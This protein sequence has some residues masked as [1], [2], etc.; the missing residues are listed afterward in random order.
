MSDLADF[1][2]DFCRAFGG[3]VE[4][5]A[6]G[7]HDVLLPESVAAQLSVEPLQR[8]AFDET[9]TGEPFTLL[10]YGHPLVERMVELAAASPACARLFI[11]DVRLHKT[12]LPALARAALSLSNASLAE[13]SGAIASR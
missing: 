3:I 7:V 13:V 1:V 12:S 8:L 11:T 6:Y 2:L 5:P 10:S 9:A 4:P